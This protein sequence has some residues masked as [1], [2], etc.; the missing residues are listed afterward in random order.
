AG[1][2]F[3]TVE[4]DRDGVVRRI[5]MMGESGGSVWPQLA[6]AAA[7]RELG[8]PWPAQVESTPHGVRLIAGGFTREISTDRQGRMLIRW[9]PDRRPPRLRASQVAGPWREGQKLHANRRLAAVACWQVASL[10]R[11][12]PTDRARE[13]Y[14]SC[15]GLSEE[16]DELHAARLAAQ[17]REV[18][19]QPDPNAPSADAL[20]EQESQTEQQLQ[21]LLMELADILTAPEH[22][23]GVLAG[24]AD[25]DPPDLAARQRRVDDLLRLIKRARSAEPALEE[26]IAE[27]RREIARRVKGKTVLIGSTATGAADFVPTPVG[28]RTPGVDVHAAIL[29]TLLSG[30]FLR[31]AGV[32]WNLLAIVLCGGAVTLLATFRP[33]LQAAVASAA[34]LLAFGWLNVVGVFV[35]GGVW[36]ALVAPLA[37]M[38]ASFLVVTA[39]RQLTEERARRRIRGMFSQALSPELVDRLL[40]DPQMARLGGERREITCLFSDLAGFT[41]LSRRL[42]S[43]GTVALLN[44]YFDRVTDVVQHG[45]GGYLNKFLG[46][47]VLALFGAPVQQPDH[48]GRALHAALDCHRQVAELNAILAEEGA[49]ARLGL[50]VGVASG[51][52][53]VGNCGSSERMDYTAIGDCVNLASRLESAC[54]FF[55]AATL[56]DARAWESAKTPD[57]LARPLGSVWITGVSD[58]VEVWELL[59]LRADATADQIDAADRFAQAVERLQRGDYAQAA[60]TFQRLRDAAPADRTAEVFAELSSQL[61][62]GARV[63]KLTCPVGDGTV[64]IAVAG[65]EGFER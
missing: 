65:I 38:G 54:K 8:G 35:C 17:R 22:V 32:G 50:R 6:L 45:R 11:K 51:E 64:R 40:E 2:G 62:T 20:A 19:D 1:T 42:G 36:V 37:A 43:A 30:C 13:L 18:L 27:Y 5:R 34:V 48:A 14:W 61:A 26:A 9:D 3:V 10:A 12:L 7:G 4:P 23:E 39:Y 31:E 56:V 44:R 47:G 16:L 25:Q 21:Q 57:L 24:D 55:A 52:S 49:D 46:D 29:R 15:T 28:H 60:E 41:S 63:E 58:P 33:V 59:S 53:M